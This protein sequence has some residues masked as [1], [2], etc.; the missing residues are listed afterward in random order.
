MGKECC[1]GAQITFVKVE[2]GYIPV[3]GGGY[4]GG[5]REQLDAEALLEND[6]EVGTEH[7]GKPN[8]QARHVYDP[9]GRRQVGA[10][11]KQ[12]RTD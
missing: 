11:W 6:V 1:G 10:E 4:P 3:C 7:G 9:V 8:N 5:C 12:R 2:S